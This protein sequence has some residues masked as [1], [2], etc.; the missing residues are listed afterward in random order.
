MQ[1]RRIP[2]ILLSLLQKHFHFLNE[3]FWKAYKVI[4][5]KFFIHFQI[6]SEALQDGTWNLKM[7]IGLY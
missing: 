4:S 1:T 2:K 7:C 3:I 6:S 5:L